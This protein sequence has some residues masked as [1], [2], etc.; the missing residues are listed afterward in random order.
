MSIYAMHTLWLNR[1]DRVVGASKIESG[2]FDALSMRGV[3]SCWFGHDHFSDACYIKDG[4]LMGYGRVGGYTP[5]VDWERDGGSLPFPLGARVIETG[6]RGL[7]T[8]IVSASAAGDPN[9][10]NDSSTRNGTG[11]ATTSVEAGSVLW[12]PSDAN[13]TGKNS[14]AGIQVLLRT[15]SAADEQ[16]RRDQHAVLWVAAVVAAVVLF[17]GY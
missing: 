6:R 15:A 8:F 9:A 17:F 14:A 11:P 16:R 2:M 4:L 5:P 12:L 13:I 3:R 7:R 1:K 10:P